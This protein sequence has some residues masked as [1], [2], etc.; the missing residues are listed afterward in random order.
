MTTEALRRQTLADLLRRTA[1]RAPHEPGIRCGDTAWSWAEFDAVVTRLAAGLQAEGVTVGERVAV[2]ARNSHGF[3]A[4][5]FALARIGAVLVPVN[6]MLNADEAAYI[7]RHAGA[8]LLAVD[9]ALA[10]LGRAAAAKDTQVQRL[11]WLP[12]EAPSEPIT[13]AMSPVSEG[14]S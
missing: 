12:S 13:E 7:L 11:L 10:S 2:L 14:R 6:F 1:L 9:S 3:A 5:R 8:R 4:L